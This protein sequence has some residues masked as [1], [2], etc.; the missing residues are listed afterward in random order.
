MVREGGPPTTSFFALFAALR[1]TKQRWGKAL[2]RQESRGWAA[3]A[4]HD[5][6][7]VNYDLALWCDAERA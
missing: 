7:V 3:F 2:H 1:E 5:T 4:D 6:L